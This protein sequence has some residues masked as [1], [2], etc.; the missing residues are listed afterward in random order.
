MKTLSIVLLC[1]FLHVAYS[2]DTLVLQPG[3]EGKDATINDPSPN[4]NSGNTSKFFC[5]GWTHS[6]VPGKHRALVDFDLSMIPPDAEI[7]DARLN[8]YYVCLEPTYIPQSGENESYLQLITSPWEENTVSWNNQPSITEED[9]VYLPRSTE[10][11]QDYTNI[12]VTIPIRKIFHEPEN[13]Y[14]LM[15]RLIDEY[16]YNCLLFASGDY[17]DY[18]DKR[19]KLQVIYTS[20]PVPTA[21]FEYQADSLTYSFS[22]ISTSAT[23]W[24][25][26]FGDGDTS[27]QQNPVH[28]YSQPGIYSVCLHVEDTCY[29]ANHCET[30]DVCFA[31]PEAGFS[32][33]A[34]GLTVQFQDTTDVAGEYYWDFGDGY[35]SSLRDP[36]HTYDA[37]DTYDV[38]L[39]ASNS[40]GSDTTC[41][42]LDICAPPK[43]DFIFQ[44]DGLVVNFMNTS[45]EAVEY[46]W[47]FGDGY[48]SNLENP[49]HEYESFDNYQVCL[50]T[51]NDCGLDTSCQSLYLSSVSI[52]DHQAESITI[53]PNPARDKVFIKSTITGNCTV[54]L[55]DL[56]GKQVIQQEIYLDKE[57]TAAV[58][59]KNLQPGIYCLRLEQG[60]EF[61]F[62]KLAIIH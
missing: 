48:Y 13:Y 4:S 56:S 61:I 8:L 9:Q 14:G 2:Q 18:P 35:F 22:G 16:P 24:H 33:A 28:A 41:Q 30:I 27:S 32:Y 10:P 5:M 49:W 47:D 42:L 6:G 29:F 51:W 45:E 43:S 44:I 20:C 37:N 21:D 60:N 52:P 31:P 26:D 57:E 15:L 34:E 19:L 58:P 17:L 55:V 38:C 12:D 25:W 36:V 11:E 54:S 50:I 40:C 23:L 3:P 39:M 7:L 62:C 1:L 53:Y 46:Y 59:L